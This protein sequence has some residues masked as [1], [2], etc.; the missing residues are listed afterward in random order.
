MAS[1]S[2]TPRL[3]LNQWAGAD[4]PQRIDFNADNL[5]I[6]TQLGGHV[7]DGDKHVTAQDKAR[8]D[9]ACTTGS[10]FGTNAPARKIA[11]PFA[12]KAVVVF[13]MSRP[14]IAHDTA[15]NKLWC[16][17]GGATTEYGSL[18]LSLAADGFTVEQSSAAVSGNEYAALNKAG[19]S[20][21]YIAWQ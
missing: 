19:T 10:Y 6:D 18:G 7:A 12:P 8:W 21:L 17:S 9:G 15:D 4:A 14:P 20:Y 11:L 2:K 3:A 13:P 1:S 16:Y 5:K